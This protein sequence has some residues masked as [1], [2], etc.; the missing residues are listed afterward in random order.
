MILFRRSGDLQQYLESRRTNNRSI[1]FV[2]TLGALHAGHLAL[3]ERS[4]R[5]DQFTVCSIFVNPT[6]FNEA[7]DL[8]KYPRTP[9]KDLE[10]LSKVGCDLAFLPTVAE[11]YPQGLNRQREW[12]FGG[13]DQRLEAAHRPGHFAGVAQVVER[14]LELVAPN[15]L[16]L[17]QKD[18]QQVAII[19]GL[20]EQLQL[21]IEIDMVPTVREPDG[22][23]MSSRNVHLSPEAR[24]AAAQIF[25]VLQMVRDRF[26][27]GEEARQLERAALDLLKASEYLR[28]EYFEI[29]DGQTLEPW[30][31]Q[32]PRGRPV[33]C[34]AVLAEGVRLIDNHIL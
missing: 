3:I 7:A 10:W 11:V 15:R 8:E 21:P 19:R 18:Y 29:V 23:A 17:G 25:E 6:Q 4:R 31:A 13:L 14:L 5:R 20:T 32:N 12:N 16:Y 24:A 28:P 34:T 26:R 2:P 27:S 30:S 9:G 22:L 33:A 1:G